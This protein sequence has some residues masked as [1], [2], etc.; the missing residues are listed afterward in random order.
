MEEK[1]KDIF[2][3]K[4][5]KKIID[6]VDSFFDNTL[7]YPRQMIERVWWRNLLYFCGEHWIEYVRTQ[8]TFRRRSVP[9]Y[10]PTPVSNEIRS[11][12]NTMKSLLL[13]QKMIPRIWPNTNER[14]DIDAAELGEKLLIWMESINDYEFTQEKEKC[15]IWLIIAGTSFMRTI[16]E[17]AGGK[18]YF[19]DT[20]KMVSTGEVSSEAVVPFNV[21][22][23]NN[24]DNLRKKRWVGIK[25]LKNREWVEDTFR[26]KIAKEENVSMTSDYQ[27][28]LMKLVS[29][30]SPWKGQGLDTT[31]VGDVNEDLVVYKEVEFKPT[32]YDPQ[33]RYVVTCG[34]KMLVNVPRMP[35]MATDMNNWHY[36][37]TD[38]HFYYVPGRFWSDT[39]VNDLISPQNT[40]NEVDQTIAI[41]RKG[42]SRPRII[43][44]GDV[45]LKK[46]NEGGQGFLAVSYNP[47][48]S[49]GKAPSFETGTP[50]LPQIFNEREIQ[51]TQI[52]DTAGDPKNI[53]RGQAPSAQSSGIQVD[54][55]RETAER[56]HAPDIERYHQSMN[57]VY[58]KRLL[59]PQEIYTEERMI[60]IAGRGNSIEVRTFKA[61]DLR[62]N[63]D[64]RLELDSGLIS[65]K[66]GQTDILMKMISSGFFSDVNIPPSTKE[67]VFRRLGM[68]G[69]TDEVNLDVERAEKENAS[70]GSGD[71][72][73]IFLAEPNPKSGQIDAD[74]EVLSNDPKFKY[75]NH[76]IH[77]DV[78]RKFIISSTFKELPQRSQVVAYHHIDNHNVL[79]QAAQQN[80][81]M[82]QM[83]MQN[84][85]KPPQS[86]T[87]PESKPAPKPTKEEGNGDA[88]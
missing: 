44:P 77:F 43:V 40:I 12:V 11:Y 19:P 2:K 21:S 17:I 31:I 46:I 18:V 37:L 62:G 41:A 16:P 60:K 58:K 80:M 88:V 32:S 30:V 81:M 57:T 50:L 24:G 66:S 73:G 27:R 23:D 25:S 48:L 72:S 3:S 28:R 8:Q 67:D 82:Q 20:E 83:V 42:I 35:I 56:G 64:V 63:T 39:G 54:I 49:G 6:K 71:F 75:D 61:S 68:T 5:D 15:I 4:N 55:L 13:S 38:F 1:F 52:Q 69:F 84:A 7:D 33:G 76:Q 14:E 87:K 26:V 22:M 45:G 53:L 59:V 10:I 79:V 65:T 86:P 78:H 47:L 85:G 51:R 29:A 34:D 70:I 36:S 9:F 74:S